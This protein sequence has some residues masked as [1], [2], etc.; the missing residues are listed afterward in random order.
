MK[1]WKKRK[2]V[3][4]KTFILEQM[5][6]EGC[7]WKRASLNT[8]VPQLM[9][10]FHYINNYILNNRILDPANSNNVISDNLT[11]EEKNRIRKLAYQAIE[12]RTWND[13]FY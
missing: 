1:L 12:A 5:V 8:L 3:P 9:A 10:S 7:K 11:K 6:I 2:S 4:I 13:V